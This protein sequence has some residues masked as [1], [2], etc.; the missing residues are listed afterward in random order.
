GGEQISKE[1]NIRLLGK[2][3]IDPKIAENTDQGTPFALS[4]PASEAAKIFN[5]IVEKIRKTVENNI[6]KVK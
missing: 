2:I 1:M 5:E 4:N 3:P 6:T